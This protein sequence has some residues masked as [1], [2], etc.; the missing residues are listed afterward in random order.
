MVSPTSYPPGQKGAIVIWGLLASFPFGGMS[1][2]VLHHL[3]GIR[4]L[5]FDVW[6]VEDSDAPVLDPI[7]YWPTPEYAGNVAYLARQMESIGLSERWVFRAPGIHDSCLG[8][9]DLAG[10]RQLYREADAVLNL[11]GS[12][13]WRPEHGEIRCLV[14]L[15]TD[16]V[17]NQVRV[18]SGDAPTIETLAH[19]HHVFSYGE[20]LGAPDCGVPVERFAWQPTR[21]PVCLDWWSTDAPPAA[22]MVLT[23]VANWK[24]T[25]KDVVWQGDTYYWSKHYEF[26]RYIA[27]P[28]RATLPLELAIGAITEAELERLRR[29][30][31]RLVPSVSLVE[32]NAY[33]AYIQASAGEFTVAKDQY[34]R[35]RSGWFSDRSACYL[36]AGRPVITQDTGFGN[37]LPTGSGL[38]AFTSA[39]E[40]LEAIEIVANDYAGQSAA[41]RDIAREY[42]AAERVLGDVLR[43]VGLL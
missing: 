27:L 40:A 37:V 30:G 31:W 35:L 1:W 29:H 42:F 14:Y 9:R 23:T 11:C 43:R 6:Y 12:H 26:Q 33:R 17:G 22:G 18:A 3:A 41:A 13:A 10:L 5:G 20:N 39:E 36:A 25:G 34:V 2:Q 24:T 7:T 19:Y 32:P 15:E 21:P 4:R 16:P 28:S 8:G 38:F